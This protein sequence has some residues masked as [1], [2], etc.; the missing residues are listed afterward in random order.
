MTTAP[1]GLPV[2]G[3]ARRPGRIALLS[4]AVALV[5]AGA[6][7]ITGPP[8]RSSP[9]PPGNLTLAAA[10]PHA[11]QADFDPAL[12]DGPL[13]APLLFLDTTTAIGTAP[14][15]DA[16]SVRLG[17]RDATGFRELRRFPL[18]SDP[19]FAALTATGDTVV[20][21][22]STD[23]RPKVRIWQASRTAGPARL[24]TADTGAAVFYGSRYDL[25][26]TGG[27]LR[28]AA[29]NG[30]ATEVRSIPLTG[31]PV[32]VHTEIGHWSLSA[33]PWLVEENQRRLRNVETQRD[34]EVVTSGPE[35]ATCSPVWCRVLVMAAD[36]PARI[37]LM[38]PD[39]SARRRTAGGE[40]RAAV[41]DVAVLD[42]FELLAEPAPD[43][44][45]TGT[46]TLLVHDAST[47]RTVEISA[48][49]DGA[50]TGGGLL[51][52]S[53]GGTEDEITW[54]VLDLRTA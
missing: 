5:A 38:H 20:W 16:R 7:V 54:H 15:T 24:L 11:K 25:A 43:A 13:F 41:D 30:N 23:D 3:A 34:T 26:V 17:I 31:G 36:G 8:G 44:D 35:T 18:A 9:T 10:W 29:A 53:T 6:L 48:A 52:W 32:A 40:A 33:W 21:T 49:V 37:D 51:W 22:E 27:V 47:S 14:T 2:V 45:L 12:P 39:G 28:W 4:L 1:A 50:F 19:Q 46:T 42:R